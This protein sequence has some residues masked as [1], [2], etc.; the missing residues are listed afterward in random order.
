MFD[1]LLGEVD[2][3]VAHVAEFVVDAGKV[4]AY[5]KAAYATPHFVADSLAVHAYLVPVWGYPESHHSPI[6]DE[7]LFPW[8][9][10]A[11]NA[12]LSDLG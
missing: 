1:L 5:S 6:G 4:L 7:V 2:N 10:G 8:P 11:A 3:A 9:V 12:S